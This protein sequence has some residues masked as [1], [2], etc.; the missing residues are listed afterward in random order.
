[1]K[2]RDGEEPSGIDGNI[3]TI[4]VVGPDGER[5]YKILSH[6]IL[7]VL[8]CGKK[9]EEEEEEDRYTGNQARSVAFSSSSSSSSFS[10]FLWVR[11]WPSSFFPLALLLLS[12]S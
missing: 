3:E 7:S 2:I 6:P 12:A 8:D 4:V 10:L 9:K 11:T 1:M 5:M